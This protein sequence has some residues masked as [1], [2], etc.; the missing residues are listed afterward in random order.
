MSV[1]DVQA[2]AAQLEG[3]LG[4]KL[5]LGGNTPSAEDVKAFNDLLGADNGNI[6][7]WVKT[8]ASYS[9]AERKGWGAPVKVTAPAL[10]P[11][12]PAAAAPK[13]EKKAAAPAKAAP[14]PAADD[15]D[16]DLFG[17]TTEEE[18]AALAAK[19]AKDADKKKEKKAVIAKSSILFDIKVWDETIDLEA[20]AA[21]L[22]ATEKPGLTWGQHKLVPVAFGMK[23]LQMLIVIED[24]K[25]SCD[26]LEEMVMSYEDEVQSM[27]I[28]AWNKI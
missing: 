15:D 16:V 21:K 5:F 4:G 19:K 10:K 28:V 3:K 17:E 13:E 26:D 22:K 1:K 2:K 25:V 24:D 9:E 12:A 6:Y 27:D 11:V 14:A 23:K 18:Q 8:V 20:L 7:R